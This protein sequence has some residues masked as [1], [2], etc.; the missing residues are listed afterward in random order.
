VKT[1]RSGRMVPLPDPCV[2]ALRKRKAEQAADRLAAGRRWEE[3]GLVFTTRHGTP[4]EPRNLA[5]T[6]DLL[7]ERSEVRRIRLHDTR[8]T[9]ASLLAAAGTHPRTIMAILGHSQIGVTMNVYTHVATEDQRAAVGLVGGLLDR[10]AGA[11][12][13][14]SRQTQ[15]S[16]DVNDGTEE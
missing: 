6:F 1:R 7:C 12:D 16:E 10:A 13:V 5:R 11:E 4:V 15:P 8:H 2:R 9:C 3:A 14:P